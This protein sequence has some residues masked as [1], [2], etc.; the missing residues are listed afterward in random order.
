MGTTRLA[1]P[2][3]H[4]PQRYHSFRIYPKSTLEVKTLRW[5]FSLWKHKFFLSF[6]V[7]FNNLP[8]ANISL[9]PFQLLGNTIQILTFTTLSQA[10]VP[11]KVSYFCRSNNS[12][13]CHCK[14]RSFLQHTQTQKK[15]NVLQESTGMNSQLQVGI[16]AFVNTD[17]QKFM[18]QISFSSYHERSF[19]S[20][21]LTGDLW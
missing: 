13:V 19:Q 11:W 18:T 21:N 15:I 3:Q 17:R 10:V 8:L 14:P 4:L 7:T 16:S 2:K 1:S 6:R 12:S 9:S 20:D 5:V